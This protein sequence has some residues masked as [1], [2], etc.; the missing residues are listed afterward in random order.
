MTSV[1]KLEMASICLSFTMSPLKHHESSSSS[2]N[3]THN[4]S[5]SVTNISLFT[6][7]MAPPL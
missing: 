4:R 6:D 1:S 2:C 5:R 7:V 3:K